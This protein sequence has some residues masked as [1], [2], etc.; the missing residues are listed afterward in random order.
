M[1]ERK[2]LEMVGSEVSHIRPS[3]IVQSYPEY[4]KAIGGFYGDR[5]IFLNNS[6]ICRMLMTHYLSSDTHA[7]L[8]GLNCRE[9]IARDN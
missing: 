2:E 8:P 4:L 3:H 5:L 9:I 7:G 6:F 1:S